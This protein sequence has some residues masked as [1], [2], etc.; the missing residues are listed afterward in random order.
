MTF[1]R[2][3]TLHG[4]HYCVFPF[5]STHTGLACSV[6]YYDAVRLCIH[7][8]SVCINVLCYS[9]RLSWQ[10]NS[11]LSLNNVVCVRACVR[12]C[13]C[14]CLCVCVCVWEC[15][16]WVRVCA[17]CV[18]VCV[19]VCVYA[20]REKMFLRMKLC[21]ISCSDLLR[22]TMISCQWDQWGAP[23]LPSGPQSPFCIAAVCFLAACS[24]CICRSMGPACVMFDYCLFHFHQHLARKILP[25]KKSNLEKLSSNIDLTAS[26]MLLPYFSYCIWW[27]SAQM[28]KWALCISHWTLC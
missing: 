4:T 18:C 23:T 16:R 22:I 3:C 19:C 8:C 27:A 17:V 21:V 10:L 14:V 25:A 11:R 24:S 2:W 20:Y 15:V 13:V 12:V 7:W 9:I 1:W 28:N 5:M 26:T 6:N